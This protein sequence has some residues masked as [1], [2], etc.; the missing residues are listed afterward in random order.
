VSGFMLIQTG[1]LNGHAAVFDFTP[2]FGFADTPVIVLPRNDF[3]RS[4]NSLPEPQG[5]VAG[6]K[7]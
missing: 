2:A 1:F 7:H 4:S 5:F 3:R 6:R